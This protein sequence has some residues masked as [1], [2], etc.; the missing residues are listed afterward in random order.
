MVHSR[1]SKGPLWTICAEV[2][3]PIV[4]SLDEQLPLTQVSQWGVRCVSQTAPPAPTTLFRVISFFR[5]ESRS[6]V[7]ANNLLPSFPIARFCWRAQ[8]VFEGE[9]SVL[10]ASV[11]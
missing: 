6:L 1:Q 4:Q 11:Y 10:K 7:P 8:C 5:V 9:E 3:V 2:L